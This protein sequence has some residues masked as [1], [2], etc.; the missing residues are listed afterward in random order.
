MRKNAVVFALSVAIEVPGALAQKPDEPDQTVEVYGKLYPEVVRQHGVGATGPGRTTADF[1]GAPDGEKS[2]VSRNEM[3]S[4]NSRFGVRGGIKLGGDLKG[5]FQLETEF[6]VDQN[7]SGFATRD[8]FVGLSHKRWGTIK[9]GRMDTPFKGYADDVSFL[10]VSSGNF[11]STSELNR[12][13]PFGGSNAGRFHERRTNAVDYETP[14][15]VGFQGEIQ[16]S[17]GVAGGEGDEEDTATRHPHAWSAGIKWER[18][19]FAVGVGHEIHR[20][21]FGLSNNVPSDSMASADDPLVRSNDRATEVM[22]KYEWNIDKFGIHQFEIDG[23]R[24]EWTEDPTITG[25]ARSYKN[26]SYLGIWDARWLPEWRTQIH[27]V[28][29]TRGNC[30]IVAMSCSTRGLGG[31]QITA[32]A[33][34]YF[35]KRTYLFFMAQ[36]LRNDFSANFASGTQDASIGENVRQYALGINYEFSAS[37]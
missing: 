20:D 28:Q 19:P 11:V 25:K 17:N 2:I 3:E 14:E 10:G 36:W 15:I 34:Y 6:H 33:A 7:D 29:A 4:S 16:Y 24:K 32:G 22:I 5:I 8:S 13:L 35:S 23:N 37:F 31:F 21:L 26:Y 30:A 27:Y 18:G 9:I 1:A 12:N